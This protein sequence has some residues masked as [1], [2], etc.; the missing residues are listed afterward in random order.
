MNISENNEEEIIENR[1]SSRTVIDRLAKHRERLKKRN[2]AN[3]K[4]EVNKPNKI[5]NIAFE[6]ESKMFKKEVEKEEENKIK[7]EIEKDKENYCKPISET[8]YNIPVIHKKKM[9][10]KVFDGL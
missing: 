7:T 2:E 6:L 1:K 10:K 4:K 5:K 9:K 3:N 8:N